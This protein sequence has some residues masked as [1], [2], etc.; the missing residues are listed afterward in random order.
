VDI[1]KLHHP[2]L[3]LND[4]HQCPSHSGIS[5]CGALATVKLQL[6]S[7]A[8]NVHLQKVLYASEGCHTLVKDA[9]C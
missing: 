4:F 7:T 6:N 3:A 8:L 2:L 1:D 9:V 5:C